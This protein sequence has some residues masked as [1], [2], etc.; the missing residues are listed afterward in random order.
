MKIKYDSEVD[1]LTVEVSNAKIDYAEEV[2]GIIVHFTKEGKPVVLEILDASD[3]LSK[4]T[5][6]AMQ[7]KSEGIIESE[8]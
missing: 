3:F 6:I 1:I 2:G 5:K 8:V 4:S 7:K